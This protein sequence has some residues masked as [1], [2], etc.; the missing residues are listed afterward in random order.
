L[1]REILVTAWDPRAYLQ[2]SDVRFRAGLDLLARI[3]PGT[4]RT[5]YDL[6]CGTG[7]LTRIFAES[8]PDASVTGIDSSPE[9][10]AEAR[11]EFP[12]ICFVQADISLWR[13]ENIPDLIISNAVL[14]WVPSR[15]TLLLSLLRMLRPGGVLATQIPRHFEMASHAVLKRWCSKANGAPRLNPSW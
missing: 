8:F 5:V 4:Y 14:H 9:M 7:H 1:S 13:P 11:R 2:F 12:G 10:L 3:P 6:G 15:E